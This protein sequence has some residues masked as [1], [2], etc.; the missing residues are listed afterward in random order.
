MNQQ[1]QIEKIPAA[2]LAEVVF[3][4]QIVFL[5][6]VLGLLFH[7][8]SMVFVINVVLYRVF[9]FPPTLYVPRFVGIPV[10]RRTCEMYC[11]KLV[12]VSHVG[13]GDFGFYGAC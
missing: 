2:V 5:F 9:S 4:P 3:Y 8:S 12:D 7:K 13:C 6:V 11:W 10:L 1:I